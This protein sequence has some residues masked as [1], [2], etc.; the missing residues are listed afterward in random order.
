M[1]MVIGTTGR[2]DSTV[3]RNVGQRE[4]GRE[5]RDLEAGSR[6]GKRREKRDGIRVQRSAD[7]GR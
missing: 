4:I 2:K 7:M 3:R 1:G 5:K 6:T